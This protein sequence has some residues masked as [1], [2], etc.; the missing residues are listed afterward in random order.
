MNIID[1]IDNIGFQGPNITFVIT[2]FFLFNQKMFFFSYLVFYFANTYLNKIL[3]NIFRQPRPSGWKAINEA[4]NDDGRVTYGMPSGHAQWVTFSTTFLYLVKKDRSLL[5]LELF[6]CALTIYQRWK[7][8][9]HS[10]DQ[11]AAG[12]L[13]GASVAYLC[14]ELTNKY[15]ITK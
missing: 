11:L 13:V 9:R 10:L 6:I 14:Y 2:A 1:I 5:L 15:L 4:D 3:K 7:Y 12:S 8:R